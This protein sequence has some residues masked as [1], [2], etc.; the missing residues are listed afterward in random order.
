MLYGKFDI[1]QSNQTIISRIWHV[2][3]WDGRICNNWI[4]HNDYYCGR[5]EASIEKL[6]KMCINPSH[7]FSRPRAPILEP[8]NSKHR[9]KHHAEC[10]VLYGKSKHTTLLSVTNGSTDISRANLE[11]LST[12]RSQQQAGNSSTVPFPCWTTPGRGLSC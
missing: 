12:L 11:P 8:R 7:L 4:A 6:M 2:D 3:Y 1:C 5:C 10:W 9:Q